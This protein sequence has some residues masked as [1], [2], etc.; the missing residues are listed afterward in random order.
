MK[1]SASTQALL[2]LLCRGEEV[3]GSKLG[4]ALGMSRTAV[5]KKIKQLQEAGVEIH[6][7]TAKGYRLSTPLNLLDAEKIYQVVADNALRKRLKLDIHF[8]LSSTSDH[9][10]K[11]IDHV[12]NSNSITFCLAEHLSAARGRLGRSWHAP[13]GENIY[14]SSLW[15]LNKDASE[16][17]GLSLIIG[18][19]VVMALQDYGFQEPLSV[20]WP[21]DVMCQNK[22]MAGILIEIVG[23]SNQEA[24]LIIGIGLNV[25]MH[26]KK[27]SP[28]KQPW[29]SLAEITNTLH[30][31]NKIVGL[32]IKRLSNMMNTFLE[33]GF[34]PFLPL[35]EKY[36][37][38]RGQHI[39][40]QQLKHYY[41]GR[42]MGIDE[43]GNLLLKQKT[44]GVLPFAIGEA[45]ICKKSS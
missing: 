13:F 43:Q 7:E 14:C 34:S 39:Q 16:L 15:S 20:K 33:E 3:S 17:S 40:L 10:K 8:S 42:V 35:W 32:L 22:K 5:W 26:A 18:L 28:I 45:S 44:G 2:K 6:T 21:N 1:L 37:Y 38:L 9:L 12:Q 29:T 11:E 30:D 4:E 36:D 31:R 24:Q 41:E 27:K 19:A 23:V 25:N